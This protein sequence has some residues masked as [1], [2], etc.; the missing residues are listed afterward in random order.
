META[1]DN[2]GRDDMVELKC[3]CCSKLFYIKRH[4][5]IC[6]QRKEKNKVY[7]IHKFCSKICFNFS[8]Q[9]KTSIKCEQCGKERTLKMSQIKKSK[10]GKHFCSKSCSAIYNNAHKTTG[11]R[12]SK[13]EVYIQE[14]LR[15][16]FPTHDY[17]HFNRTDTINAELDI[18][19]P[20]L[21]LAFELNGI[22][23]Y[24]PIYGPE[25]LSSIRTND[26]RKM[27]ACLEKG[28]ELCII[29]ISSVNYFKKLKAQKYL[30]I[31]TGIINAKI[32]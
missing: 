24:E 7:K 22:F 6:K 3:E 1:I 19:I 25:K 9:K 30:D 28:I 29:D 23:H 2:L 4:H 14:Q 20:S 31:I 10:S 5:A 32:K 13:M 12:V 11:T 27:Q 21:K 26:N 18:Y 15:I 17:F 8:T 16:L